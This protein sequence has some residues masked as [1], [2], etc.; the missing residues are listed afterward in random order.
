MPFR[1]VLVADSTNIL[2]T[3]YEASVSLWRLT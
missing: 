2:D 1:S 3:V